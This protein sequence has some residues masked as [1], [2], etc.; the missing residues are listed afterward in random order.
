VSYLFLILLCIA[1]V[2]LLQIAP[3]KMKYISKSSPTIK[4]RLAL[5]RQFGRLNDCFVGEFHAM[6]AVI[7]TSH[8][9]IITGLNV[10]VYED[11]A[12]PSTGSTA[13]F[14]MTNDTNTTTMT[15]E[16]LTYTRNQSQ[17][18]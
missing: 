11:C 6:R 3:V 15:T 12:K 7:V 2:I 17:Q 14:L 4:G 1:R 10:K 16:V 9:L 8:F 18:P 13:L 5:Y